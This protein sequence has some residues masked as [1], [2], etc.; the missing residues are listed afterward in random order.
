MTSK[1]GNSKKRNRQ[2][3]RYA[4][5]HVTQCEPTGTPYVL[6]VNTNTGKN[7]LSCR[8]VLLVFSVTPFKIDQNYRVLLQ[9]REFILRESHKH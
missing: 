6:C 8:N 3:N 2:P 1:G 4:L 9:K 7:T 5:P